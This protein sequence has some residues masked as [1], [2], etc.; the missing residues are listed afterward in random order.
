MLECTKVMAKET[1]KPAVIS[2][3][4]NSPTKEFLGAALN[5]SWQLAL[6]VLVP[7]L[8]GFQLDKVLNTLPAFTIIGFLTAMAGMAIVVWR[9]MKRYS[10]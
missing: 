6:V 7:I 10:S 8:G 9:A 3:R 1:D 2:T 4:S 5:M